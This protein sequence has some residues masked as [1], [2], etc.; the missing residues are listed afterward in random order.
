MG[1]PG[2]T[3]SPSRVIRSFLAHPLDVIRPIGSSYS[4]NNVYI[5][6]NKAVNNKTF[7]KIIRKGSPFGIISNGR[8]DKDNKS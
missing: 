4:S 8:N 5:S 2:T 3:G 6:V 7:Y 1:A